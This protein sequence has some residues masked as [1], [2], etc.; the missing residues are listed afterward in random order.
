M[1]DK[2]NEKV[3][4]VISDKERYMPYS[5]RFTSD[6]ANVKKVTDLLIKSRNPVILVGWGSVISRASPE[7]KKLA[8]TLYIP[9]VSTAKAKGIMPGSSSLSLGVYKVAGLRGTDS[10]ENIIK[11]ADVILAIGTSF[12]QI[13]KQTYDIDSSTKI[14]NVN[15]DFKDIGKILKHHIG[16][17]ADAKTFL[18]QVLKE[19]GD[20]IKR[21]QL[22]LD[23][24]KLIREIEI[25]KTQWKEKI[26][27]M[28]QNDQTPIRPIR[29]YKEIQEIIDQYPNTIITSG[30]GNHKIFAMLYLET[31][32]P[33]RILANLN[34]GCMGA[35]LPL[36]IGAKIADRHVL[37]EENPVIVIE[38]DG[39][40]SMSMS[41]LLTSLHYK[42]PVIVCVFNDSAL[43]TIRYIQKKYYQ[44]RII[45]TEHD[46]VDF[47]S[48]SRSMGCYSEKIQRP[49]D[50]RQ[51]LKNAL[52]ANKNNKTA[53][54]DMTTYRD[55]PLIGK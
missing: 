42:I 22:R 28:M 26:H 13:S 44:N 11:N 2:L 33:G 52:K 53:V 15:I 48:I 35:G 49:Q 1:I 50:I 12:S 43:S 10:A 46:E 21:N 27:L 38:G 9:V 55:T 30:A 7:I 6:S 31:E 8:E 34:F 40:F 32:K 17:I 3:N 41:E 45:D 5:F 18:I 36:A 20:R 54:L 25:N 51:G 23:R 29:I 37:K 19:I 4:F 14:I 16:I 47:A 39:G 24:E